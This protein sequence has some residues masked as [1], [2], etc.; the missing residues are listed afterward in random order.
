MKHSASLLIQDAARAFLVIQRGGDSEHFV[1]LWEFPGG[2][3]DAG[4]TP[5][6]ALVREVREEV[7]V[8]AE[9]P[10]GEPSCFITTSN[11]EVEY[12]FFGWQC[13][14]PRPEIRLSDEHVAFKW[15]SFTE[16]RALKLMEP[17]RNFLERFWHQEQ[18]KAY[19]V[20]RPQYEAYALSLE[21]V[22]KQACE[23]T[24]QGIVVQA[25]AKSVSAF[26]EKCVR[27]L[28]KH[29]DPVH[30]FTDLCGGRVITQTLEQMA[31]VKLFVE[32]NFDIIERDDKGLLLSEDKFGYRDMHYLVRLLPERAA[33]IGFTPE[34]I[35][36]IGGR[37]AELQVRTLVQHAWADILHDRMYKPPLRLSSEA[38]R[39]GALLAAIMEDGD[40]SFN[41]LAI[42]IDS[43]AANYTT[44]ASKESVEQEIAVQELI[45]ANEKDLAARIR[46][47]LQLARLTG[48][49]GSYARV[50]EILSP[51]AGIQGPAR[52]AILLELGHASCQ[53]HRSRPQS[54]EY[55][56]GQHKLE[57]VITLCTSTNLTSVPNLRQ[58]NSLHVRALARLAWSWEAV[59]HS[60]GTSLKFYREA[61]ERQPANPYHLA[62]QLGF[63]IFCHP[64]PGMIDSMRTAIRQGI[65]TCREHAIA[66]AELPYALFTAGRLSFL[67]GETT[68][69]VGLYARGLR[70]FFDGQSCVSEGVLEDEIDWVRRI[71]RGAVEL[72]EDHDWI[73]RLIKLGR[74]FC[75]K[76]QTEPPPAVSDVKAKERVLIIAGGAAS[77]DA[78]TLDRV[79]PCLEKAL[80]HFC[81]RVICG[82]TTVGIPG[83]VGELAAKLKQAGKK[84]FEL[85]GYIPRQLPVGTHE[86]SRYDCFVV[87]SEDSDFSPG[88][89]LRT[90]E[91]LQKAGT[92]PDHVT[93]LGIGGGL[94]SS[95]EYHIALALGAK[96]GVVAGSG[97]GADAIIADPV[98]NGVTTLLAVPL[99]QASVQA[100]V[101]APAPL[102][103]RDKL[104]EMAKAF[105][106]HYISDNPGRLPE[107]MRPWENLRETYKTANLEQARYAVEILR[108]TGFDV[109]RKTG[110]PDAITSF[111]G[112]RFKTDVEQMAELEHGRWNI[113]RLREGWRFGATRDNSKKIHNCLVN[114]EKLPDDIREYDRTSILAFPAI[115]AQAGLEVFRK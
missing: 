56:R 115:L 18:I 39:T 60:E 92:T 24:C 7:G 16:A 91:D 28:D 71:H 81:G 111:A 105:H 85:V 77:M 26:A 80:E 104:L 109:R 25:R 12:G 68:V 6:Q 64:N 69:A 37:I 66:G 62:N 17:H 48:P 14:G 110:R 87:V 32:H 90:W 70:H 45:L 76:C 65:V 75:T 46:I 94:V 13:L 21:K 88:Q 93:L 95:T 35:A 2:K 23:H 10:A 1:G 113:E 102:H 30:Q 107:N 99:D 11:G 100:F 73:E 33:L 42:E 8:A 54:L 29:P 89:I 4:E 112:E 114:W 43:M 47:A 31:A 44:Y 36:G 101:T 51:L 38:K 72:P 63:E 83:C 5:H 67:L 79:R 20:E 61:L 22:L 74:S 53:V 98:W 34:E 55:R 9:V 106:A 52:P 96:V 59:P 84:Q 108:A 3:I 97:G 19:Q 103:E 57:E 41:R 27:K 15:V 58:Q 78:D 86:D 49:C 40:R 50:V 82:G